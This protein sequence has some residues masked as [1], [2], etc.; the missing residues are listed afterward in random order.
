[1][2]VH[3]EHPTQTPEGRK[4]EKNAPDAFNFDF[5]LI[6]QLVQH[7]R[8]GIYQVTPIILLKFLFHNQKK[9]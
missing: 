4:L 3:I 1:M 9:L 8:A 2:I 7:F 5:V 6:L